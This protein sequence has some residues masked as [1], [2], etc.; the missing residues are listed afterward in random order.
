MLNKHFPTNCPVLITQCQRS[1]CRATVHSCTAFVIAQQVR[2]LTPLPENCRSVP[3]TYVKFTTAYSSWMMS[4]QPLWALTHMAHT[5]TRIPFKNKSIF[6]FFC[7]VL[8]SS[9]WGRVYLVLT[10]LELLMY[11]RLGLNSEIC[12]PVLQVLRLKAQQSQW[13]KNRDLLE[14]GLPQ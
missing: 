9:Y 8:F 13:G 7:F 11:T 14:L 1:L 6:K 2:P 10:V 12:L 5:E 3:R 4:L